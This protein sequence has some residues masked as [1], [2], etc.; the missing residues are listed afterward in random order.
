M[1]VYSIKDVV[2]ITDKPFGFQLYL[3]KDRSF[4][5]DRNFIGRIID[6]AKALHVCDPIGATTVL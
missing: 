5:K 6:R 4:M 3:M 2:E 1:S